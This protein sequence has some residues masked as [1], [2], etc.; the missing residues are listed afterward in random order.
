MHFIHYERYRPEKRFSEEGFA[1]E[2]CGCFQRRHE[3]TVAL[4]AAYALAQRNPPCIQIL[5]NGVWRAASELLTRSLDCRALAASQQHIL[6]INVALNKIHEQ[7]QSQ[8]K[9]ASEN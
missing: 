2:L 7:V 1:L 8:V 6:A 4:N 3:Q 5:I 9:R